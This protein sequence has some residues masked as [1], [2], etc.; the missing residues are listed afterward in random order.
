MKKIIVIGS[1]LLIVVAIVLFVFY[2]TANTLSGKYVSES[3]KYTVEFNRDK[4]CIWYQEILGSDTFFEGTYEKED[5]VF[6]LRIKG[7]GFYAFNTTLTAEPVD[8]GLVIT[9]GSVD[10]ELFAKENNDGES[11]A[12]EDNSLVGTYIT[13][14]WSGKEAVLMLLNDGT[15]MLPSGVTGTWSV[16]GDTIHLNETLQ[17][18]TIVPGGIMYRGRFFEKVG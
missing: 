6:V 3:G 1:I 17:E 5:D 15:F 16:E 10:G 8:D 18:A 13:D 12:K 7:D 4:T 14:N 9:G 2:L 11:F